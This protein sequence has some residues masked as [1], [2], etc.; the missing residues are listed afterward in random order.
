MP[1]ATAKPFHPAYCIAGACVASLLLVLQGNLLPATS[2]GDTLVSQYLPFDETTDA[3]IA[4]EAQLVLNQLADAYAHL[5]SL[6]LQGRVIDDADSD[7]HRTTSHNVI[8]A[9][10]QAPGKYRHATVGEVQLGSTG[11][12]TYFYREQEHRYMQ[13][14]SRGERTSMS[15]LPSFYL[16]PLISQNPSLLLAA[17]SD[18]LATLESH[19]IHVVRLPDCL[20]E[21]RTYLTIQFI[22]HDPFG[23]VTFVV[24]PE[25]YLLR[26]VQYDMRGKLY[27]LGAVDVKSASAVI[28]YTLTRP[29]VPTRDAKFAWTPPPDAVNLAQATGNGGRGRGVPAR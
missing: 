20:I 16:R 3:R 27:S 21:Q 5:S 4:P 6:E 17:I 18:S 22:T 15:A 12:K 1:T 19:C 24:D 7:G 13:Y 23:G 28:D 11:R 10:Y 2:D 8:D 25:T 14:N 9:S 29:N 26:Q